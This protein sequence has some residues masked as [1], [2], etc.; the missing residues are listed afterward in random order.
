MAATEYSLSRLKVIYI[1][2][3]RWDLTRTISNLRNTLE[4]TGR[5]AEQ[6]PIP[7]RLPRRQFRMTYL[8]APFKHKHAMRHS[9]FLDHRYAFTFHNPGN[10]PETMSTVLGSMGPDTSC[11]CHFTW[12]HKGSE[13]HQKAMLMDPDLRAEDL[14]AAHRQLE[15]NN[16]EKI[17]GQKGKMYSDSRFFVMGLGGY[18][19]VKDRSIASRRRRRTLPVAVDID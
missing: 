11:T 19:Q 1:S 12:F 15:I 2:K 13:R 17:E 8:K 14:Q 10:I 7:R 9:V 6:W 16:A 4:W 3:L 18:N 5:P